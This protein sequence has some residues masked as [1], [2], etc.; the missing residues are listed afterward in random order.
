[1]ISAVFKELIR[2][3]EESVGEDKPWSRCNLLRE[4]FERSRWKSEKIEEQMRTAVARFSFFVHSALAEQPRIVISSKGRMAFHDNEDLLTEI[5]SRTL[6]RSNE[7]PSELSAMISQKI[8]FP[9]LRLIEYDC[10]KLQMLAEMLRQLYM[11]KHRVL[12][13][14]QMSRMLDVLQAFLSYHGYQYFRLDGSTNIEQRQAMMERF[15]SDP[16]IFCFILSTR[17]GGVGINLTGADTVVFYDSDWNPTM[18]AQA[19]DRCHR[20]GQT[21]NVNIYRLISEKTIEEN[22]LKKANQ[23]RR[24]GELAIDDAGFTPQF[25]KQGNLRDLFENEDIE[26]GVVQ[27]D[28]S[29]NDLESAM[30]QF[31]DQQ[32]VVAAQKCKAEA[33]VELA[34]FDEGKNSNDV[35]D[36]VD[37][38][39]AEVMKRLRPIERYAVKWLEEEYKP[40]FEEEV[41]EAEDRIRAKQDEWTKAHEQAIAAEEEAMLKL[42]SES[43][44]S[45][46]GSAELF[47]D[48]NEQR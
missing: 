20:I 31:E 44:G 23:K 22:I 10:G 13:F 2:E 48:F 34:D 18:D 46:R 45:G 9:E 29:A 25:F 8:Q 27:E 15:N 28:V 5:A 42:D 36:A 17:S 1:M 39:Y 30:A 7:D 38:K 26:V 35:E 37:E 16:R 41:K 43:H 33:K 12:I 47:V 19:Q 11:E 14:T 24:L 6:V 32:D 21:R 4:M 40:E 3:D